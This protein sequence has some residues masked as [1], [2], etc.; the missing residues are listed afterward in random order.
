MTIQATTPSSTRRHPALRWGACLAMLVLTAGCNSLPHDFSPELDWAPLL[1]GKA[2]LQFKGVVI[3]A[4]MMA[5]AGSTQKVTLQPSWR[6]AEWGR[7]D[8]STW[9]MPLVGSLV[10]SGAFKVRAFPAPM[11]P[12]NQMLEAVLFMPSTR[13]D[14]LLAMP[15]T[16]PAQDQLLSGQAGKGQDGIRKIL[17]KHRLW[18]VPA[19]ID[20]CPG[21]P[22]PADCAAA[23]AVA[24][25]INNAVLVTR[26]IPD[27]DD[28]VVVAD[29][30]VWALG[31][32]RQISAGGKNFELVPVASEPGMLEL[33]LSR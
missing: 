20:Y 18:F 32:A 4:P 13:P 9:A 19:L 21:A 23:R 25:Q 15:D 33:R 26:L 3:P 8:F 24:S 12:M 27:R 11:G 6:R 2:D 7:N 10:Q 5:S 28:L 14:I 22:A 17:E 29:G 30:K 1:E 31:K 16:L